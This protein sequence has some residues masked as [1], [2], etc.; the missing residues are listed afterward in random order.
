MNGSYTLKTAKSCIFSFSIF[1]LI[2]VFRN[3]YIFNVQFIDNRLSVAMEN[4]L[5]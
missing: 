4:I 1:V 3:L 5:R 2:V